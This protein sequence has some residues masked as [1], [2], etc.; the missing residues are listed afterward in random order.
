MKSSSGVLCKYTTSD[1]ENKEISSGLV[2]W[3]LEP[4]CSNQLLLNNQHCKKIN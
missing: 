4:F 3:P 2:I 1:Y